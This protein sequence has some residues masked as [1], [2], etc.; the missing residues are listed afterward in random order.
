MRGSKQRSW[1]TPSFHRVNLYSPYSVSLANSTALSSRDHRP[2]SPINCNH[3]LEPWLARSYRPIS[4]VLRA[5]MT[6]RAIVLNRGKLISRSNESVV[7]RQN[8]Q[9]N[10]TKKKILGKYWPTKISWRYLSL[11][12]S[13]KILAHSNLYF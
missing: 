1:F 3:R 8:K 10:K 11:F 12:F 13:I 5:M 9:K 2:K 6:D 7:S 4:K